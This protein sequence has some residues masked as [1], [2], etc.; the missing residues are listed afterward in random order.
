MVDSPRHYLQM[1]SQL[2]M[3]GEITQDDIRSI[4]SYVSNRSR[5]THKTDRTGHTIRHHN[6]GAGGRS[7]MP[8]V[9][10]YKTKRKDGE[11]K[12]I[13][14][15]KKFEKVEEK[16]KDR[17]PDLRIIE[18]G[19]IIN[20][21]VK[22]AENVSAVQPVMNVEN[23]AK[24]FALEDIRS[25]IR[26]FDELFFFNLY[27]IFSDNS[28]EKGVLLDERDVSEKDVD[29]VRVYNIYDELE[30]SQQQ[31]RNRNKQPNIIPKYYRRSSVQDRIDVNE[32]KAQFE[33]HV[34]HSYLSIKHSE[35][36][37]NISVFTAPVLTKEIDDSCSVGN[38][39]FLGDDG[40][41]IAK[42]KL[43]SMKCDDLSD[44]FCFPKNEETKIQTIRENTNYHA[45]T[46]VY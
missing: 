23:F 28:K 2:Q 39:N 34:P 36:N 13:D 14:I 30:R 35:M 11:K 8:M 45:S 40:D 4:C 21:D 31:R 16:A 24:E 37:D 32:K 9:K 12:L 17:E 46:P 18:D 6:R 22:N 19:I 20:G 5:I 38:L 44:P 41:E 33:T 1:L 29:D 3:N 7:G 25:L 15:I 42:G 10:G 26:F 27:P 43:F